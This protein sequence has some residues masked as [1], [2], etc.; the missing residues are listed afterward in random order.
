MLKVMNIYC[1]DIDVLVDVSQSNHHYSSFEHLKS[2]V[3]ELAADT[4]FDD[5][6][7]LLL[8]GFF[9]EPFK[10]VQYVLND[11]VIAT[12]AECQAEVTFLHTQKN[13][14]THAS[15]RLDVAANSQSD[16]DEAREYEKGVSWASQVSFTKTIRLQED[17]IPEFI[18]STNSVDNQSI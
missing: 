8:Q 16:I 12:Q 5:D 4:F 18:Q 3:N 1:E 9:T 2:C 15:F 7:E 13:T 14:T 11:Q 6:P 17:R 10:P